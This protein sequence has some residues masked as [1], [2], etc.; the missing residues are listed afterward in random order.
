MSI[1]RIILQHNLLFRIKISRI[2]LDGDM[3]LGGAGIGDILNIVLFITHFSVNWFW[4]V[5]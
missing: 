3:L 2:V 1:G 5:W 4:F